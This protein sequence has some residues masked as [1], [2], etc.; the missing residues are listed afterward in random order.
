MSTLGFTAPEAITISMQAAAVMSNAG[1]AVK[2][3]STMGYIELAGDGEQAIGILLQ[4][5][6]AIG[7]SVPVVV[8]GRCKV[9]ANGAFAIGDLLNSA[10]TTGKVDTKG[11][12]EH[13]IAVA[14]E[15]ATAQDDLVLAFVKHVYV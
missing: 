11:S 15:A 3:S 1:V 4:P 9:K 13:A 7:D 2:L 6:L 10:D 5:A 8:F 14:L 12:T